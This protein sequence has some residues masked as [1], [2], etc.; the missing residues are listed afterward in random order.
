MNGLLLD[1]HALIWW[2]AKSPRLSEPARAA[3]QSNA[4]AVWVSPASIYE[5][6]Y[7]SR[8][9]RIPPLPVPTLD[10]VNA[11]GLACL[12]INEHAAATAAAFPA[13]HADPFDRL[14]AAQA[15]VHGFQV[16]TKDPAIAAF[17]ANTLW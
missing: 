17:G 13:S 8:V 2:S 6:D 7:K 11:E 14:I 10:I 16:I 5:A 9:G 4:G 3:I 1:T 15:Q 12:A